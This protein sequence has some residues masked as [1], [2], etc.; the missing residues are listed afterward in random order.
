M[1]ARV[2]PPTKNLALGEAFRDALTSEPTAPE[3]VRRRRAQHRNQGLGDAAALPVKAQVEAAARALERLD[4]G[5][6]RARRCRLVRLPELG[7]FANAAHVRAAAECGH[8]AAR[9]AAVSR[10]TRVQPAIAAAAAGDDSSAGGQRDRARL[11]SR[12]RCRARA[13]VRPRRWYRLCQRGSRSRVRTHAV[14]SRIGERPR[15]HRRWFLFDGA[16]FARST[17]HPWRARGR[18][19]WR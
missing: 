2:A 1:V 3:F 6:A 12:A 9:A 10:A 8:A 19:G 17:C 11:G 4:P 15:R 7:R 5:A 18:Y 14:C 16:P 13:L